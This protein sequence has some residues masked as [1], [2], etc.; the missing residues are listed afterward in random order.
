MRTRFFAILTIALTLLA[1]SCGRDKGMFVLQGT[2]QD[3]SDS[4]LVVGLDSR[5]DRVDTIF[6]RNGSFSWSFRPDT[7]TTLILLLPDGRHYPVFAEKDVES[8]ITVPADTGLFSVTGGP[9]N[10]LFG[11]FYLSAL[12]DTSMRQ[13]A[14]RID[15]FITRDPFSEVTP[16]LIYEYMVRK[17]HAREDDLEPLIKRMSGNMQ[18]A[19]FITSL[20]SEFNK[21]LAT[22]N[23]IDNYQ[24]IDSAGFRYQF[25]DIGGKSNH[26]LVCVWASWMGDDA[27]KARDT[28]QYF[29]DK[30]RL[31]YFN[32]T[33][34]SIDVNSERWKEVISKDTVSWLSYNDPNGWESKFIKS[35][36][37]QSVPAFILF[38]GAKRIIYKT[39][40]VRDIDI[41]LNRTLSKNPI[42]EKVTTTKPSQTVRTPK[43][44]TLNL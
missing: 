40:S 28:L 12:N 7:V 5:F 21:S 43:K 10:D 39:N 33:D 17:Y 26:L 29:L 2:V 37:L 23:Y 19:P 1:V 11:S 38:T 14:A 24:V 42:K 35:T 6:C 18:D 15:S 44:L 22:N 25:A 4:I 30:Y 16:Y 41:E 8:L 3:G 32:V 20:K 34:V 36:D 31:R 13:T 9:C 27:L